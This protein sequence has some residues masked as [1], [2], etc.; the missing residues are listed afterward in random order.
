MSS[1]M[2]W[3]DIFIPMGMPPVTSRTRSANRWKSSGVVR[4]V[5][6]GGEMADWPSGSLRMAAIFLH[7]VAG[8]MTSGSRLCRLPGLEMKCLDFRS[9]SSV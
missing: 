2:C 7:F 9:R 8:Q 1:S 3:A 4:S 5:K 6:V